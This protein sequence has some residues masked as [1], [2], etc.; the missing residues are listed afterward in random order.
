[1]PTH[2]ADADSGIWEEDGAGGGGGGR[3]DKLFQEKPNTAD[4]ISS[5]GESKVQVFSTN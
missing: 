1:M 5:V 3:A 4:Q 2:R